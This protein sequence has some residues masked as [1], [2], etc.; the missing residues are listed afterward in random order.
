MK[1]K[2]TL[3]RTSIFFFLFNLI[4]VLADEHDHNVSIHFN[5]MQSSL[6]II[7]LGLSFITLHILN[8][9]Q[10]DDKEEVILWMNTV[11]PYHNRQETYAYFSLPFCQGKRTFTS[12]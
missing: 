2:M 3:F 12:M 4:G 5:Q 10:Y 6:N 9:L 7:C 11:G 1:I 8:I